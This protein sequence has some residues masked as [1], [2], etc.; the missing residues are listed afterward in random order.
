MMTQAQKDE[1]AEWMADEIAS[2]EHQ[3]EQECKT[4]EMLVIERD[5]LA[6]LVTELRV[7]IENLT[8]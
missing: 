2:L 6:E 5:D 4:T 1:Q 7:E 3:L 8:Q